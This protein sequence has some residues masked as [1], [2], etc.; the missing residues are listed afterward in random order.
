MKNKK[1]LNWQL[2][3]HICKLASYSLNTKDMRIMMR[4]DKLQKRL[5]FNASTMHT[6]EIDVV[7]G[8][9]DIKYFDLE[10]VIPIPLPFVK[11]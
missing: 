4:A 5:W 7:I 11:R 9:K 10:Y 6:D 8:G 1:D 3:E 2:E